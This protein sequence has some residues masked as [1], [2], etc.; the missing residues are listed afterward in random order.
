MPWAAAVVAACAGRAGPPLAPGPAPTSASLAAPLPNGTPGRV[1]GDTPAALAAA[2]D[3]MLGDPQWA[4]AQWGVLVVNPRTG[5][6]LYARNAGKL[7]LPASN[8]K[9]ITGAVALARLGPEHRWHTA[10]AAAQRAVRTSGTLWGNLY[11]LGSGDP[12]VSDAMQHGDAMAPIR[13]LADSVWARGVRRI[14]GDVVAWDAMWAGPSTEG[15]WKFGW[16]WDD[17]DTPSGAGVTELLF[18]DGVARVVVFGGARAGASAH[19]AVRPTPSA[20]PVDEY[21][22]DVR[23]VAAGD[24]AAR[25]VQARWNYD[26]RQYEFRGAVA[27]HDSVVLE[28]G[29]HDPRRAYV[30]ALRDALRA[31]GISV[32]GAMMDAWHTMN[33]DPRERCHAGCAPTPPRLDTLALLTSAP[34]RDV[35]PALE[36]P[37]QNQIAEALFLT[38]GRTGTGVA[39]GDSA[40]RVVGDQ[41]RAWG[42]EP[43]RD[44]VVRDGSGLSRH[45]FV[46]PTALVRVLDAARHLADGT[47]VDA[48]PAAGVD[49]TLAA[50]LRGTAAAGRVHAKTGSV[51]RVR[52]LSGYVTTADG[53]LLLFSVLCNNYTTPSA[54]VTRV[55]DAIALRLATLRALVP[56]ATAAAAVTIPR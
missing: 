43:E 48:L 39:S 54:T 26:A 23:T 8:E 17:L 9:L 38:L 51:D 41:L 30:A 31:R 53:E 34:L 5:D 10:V 14:E 47:F 29:I 3:S 16:E 50:R 15:P 37:S 1:A 4:T 44:A 11:V 36:K 22:I 24:T 20:V 35:L 42:V 27:V 33:L 21:P 6:T 28:L 18:N 12:T 56:G 7:F 45:D 2:V 19:V 55:Q 40:R 32:Q 46:T 49:G 25:T 13:A 52:S